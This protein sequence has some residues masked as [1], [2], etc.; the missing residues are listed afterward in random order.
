MKCANLEVQAKYG[1]PVRATAFCS[2]FRN[3]PLLPSADFQMTPEGRMN[4]TLPKTNI[5]P[6]N[7]WL[8]Y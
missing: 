5:A 2:S 7:G 6:E 8:E 1:S 4:D 3:V